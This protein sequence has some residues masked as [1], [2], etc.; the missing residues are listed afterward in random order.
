[1]YSLSDKRIYI[2]TH[3]N[4]PNELTEQAIRAVDLLLQ[5]G[6][7]V[8]NQTPLLKG[9]NDDP[10]ILSDL[11]KALSFS[12]IPPYYVFLGRPTAG[13]HHF[14]VPVEEAIDIFKEAIKDC[15]GLAK[16]LRLVMSHATGKIEIIDK[17]DGNVY[18][19][20]FRAAD[21]NLTGRFMIRRSNPE[22]LWF[23]DYTH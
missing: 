4:H 12:G 13:N 8:A 22:A 23:D 19:R 10:D 6:V 11:F 1:M 17:K 9:V 20:Y 7:I 14:A 5:A 2:M 3:F 15:A 18:F 16:R 21:P